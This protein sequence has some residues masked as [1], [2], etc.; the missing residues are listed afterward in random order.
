MSE[1]RRYSDDEKAAALAILDACNGELREA[2]RQAG[3]PKSSLDEW[4]KGR[5][6]EA[7]PGLRTEK[8]ACLADR[9]EALAENLVSAAFDKIEGATLP[10]VMT[11][12]GIA[13]DKMRLLREQPTGIHANVTFFE[14]VA[15]ASQVEVDAALMQ[16]LERAAV[17]PD[18]VRY[19]ME[20]LASAERLVD[21][22]ALAPNGSPLE[23]IWQ[24]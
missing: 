13:V 7:C 1:R 5:V 23:P 6:S 15:V 19:V 3:V 9:F 8:K 11:G 4:Q 16:L 2:A 18:V 14:S 12:A 21:Q 10:G 24:E 20:R 17:A 22:P